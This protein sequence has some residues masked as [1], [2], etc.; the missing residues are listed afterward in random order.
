[1]PLAWDR[2]R[3]PSVFSA[4]GVGLH[5]F[6]PPGLLQQ[7]T[8]CPREQPSCP[9][10]PGRASEPNGGEW[11][12]QPAPW[13]TPA[14][15]RRGAGVLAAIT[16]AA[17]SLPLALRSAPT[18]LRGTSANPTAP[19]PGSPFARTQPPRPSG[20]PGRGVPLDS[21]AVQQVSCPESL[22]GDLKD[23]CGRI[24]ASRPRGLAGVEI[25]RR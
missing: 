24:R 17:R 13:G 1:M 3:Q 8:P 25:P 20:R 7:V 22:P 12:L 21:L 6:F 11:E 18:Q 10:L 2:H 14:C 16:P 4:S 5:V 19:L 15:L 23:H 9:L